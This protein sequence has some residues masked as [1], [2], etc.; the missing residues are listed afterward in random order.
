[1]GN[2]QAWILATRPKTLPAAVGPVLV[3]SALAYADKRFALLPALAALGIS[4]LLQIG[5]NLANDYFDGIKGID[6]TERLGPIRVTQSGLIAP[7]QVKSAMLLTFS[8]A[9]CLGFYLLMRGGWPAFL[10][11]AACILAALGYSG[12]P[13]PLA[14]HGLGDLFVF[15]F[16]GLVAVCGTYYVQAL[17]LTWI[18]FFIAVAVGLPITAILVI[19][20]LRDMYTDQKAGKNTLAVILGEHLSKIEYALLLG[21]AYGFIIIIWMIGWASFWLLLPLVS[22]PWAV[23]LT[24][25]VMQ[26][27]IDPNLN[28]LLAKTARLSLIYSVLLSIGVIMSAA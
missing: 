17:Q 27:D 7:A 14:S 28:I 10:I 25:S 5:V 1:M 12:G 21:L 3:G 13:F 9:A 16:F 2:L 18:V 4:L 24:W 11:G 6:T 19:N 15:I 20:N 26:S 8:L 23:A 22:L